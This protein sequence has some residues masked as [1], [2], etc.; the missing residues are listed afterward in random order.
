MTDLRTT[1]VSPDVLFSERVRQYAADRAP[2][3][4]QLLEAGC[5]WGHPLD[6]GRLDVQATGVDLDLPAL[7][8]RTRARADL[9]AW[10]LGDLRDVPM[11]PRAF[12]VVHAPYLIERL[13]NAELVLDRMAAA[14]KPGGLLL[15]RM[16]DRDTAFGF[17]D[18]NV[19]GLL[20]RLA[21][22]AASS[23]VPRPRPAARRPAPE[24]EHVS[25]TLAPEP[26]DG[27]R[28]DDATPPD[29]LPVIGALVDD[30]LV[31]GVAEAGAAGGRARVPGGRAAARRLV[32]GR[33]DGNGGIPL[34]P[35]APTVY[36][37]V[38][39]RAGMEWYCGMRGLVVAEQYASRD[40]MTVLGAGTGLVAAACRSV[41]AASRGRLTA[42]HSEVVLV[43]RK[44]ENRYARVI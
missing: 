42:S 17:L 16:R 25:G 39:S 15:V 14:L 11:P 8:A 37:R 9:D 32:S 29:G 19:P 12:D 34:P 10:H 21:V 44:P 7:R 18:R 13:R 23:R 40:C 6:L 24:P 36:D 2:H 27:F 31:D 41:A 22:R 43:I 28:L 30:A 20:R 26:R 3:R 1:P 5:G 38:A 33:A 35:P 4:L